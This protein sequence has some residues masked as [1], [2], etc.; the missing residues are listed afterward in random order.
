[1]PGSHPPLS[2]VEVV[3]ISGRHFLKKSRTPQDCILSSCPGN[4]SWN[5]S[6][7]PIS[8]ISLGCLG[9]RF[10]RKR[11]TSPTLG[12]RL[13]RASSWLDS[14]SVKCHLDHIFQ[15]LCSNCCRNFQLLLRGT[16]FAYPRRGVRD[17]RID[18]SRFSVR[19]CEGERRS[20]S[21]TSL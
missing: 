20:C 4:N 2:D 19:E 17:R 5:N 9:W 6:V 7:N 3:L 11:T 14:N 21:P 15:K 1:M 16:T 18:A 8:H 10:S 12:W 13:V